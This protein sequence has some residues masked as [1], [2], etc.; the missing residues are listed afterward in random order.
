MFK[1]FREPLAKEL[2]KWIYSMLP[3]SS[4]HRVLA[5]QFL[6]FLASRWMLRRQEKVIVFMNESFV[7]SSKGLPLTAAELGLFADLLVNL[8]A[9]LL[10]HQK[11]GT[12]S[13]D[14]LVELFFRNWW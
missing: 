11:S 6:K 5:S 1:C 7:E 4:G 13:S 10:H 3:K 12:D 9:F 14:L 8:D 2:Q